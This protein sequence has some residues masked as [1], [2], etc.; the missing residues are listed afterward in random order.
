MVI[1][2]KQDVIAIMDE[3]LLMAQAATG[4]YLA[5]ELNGKD[6]YPCG[7][8]WV[9]IYSYRGKKIRANSWLGKALAE[10]GA[11]KSDYEKCFKIWDPS[12]SMLQNIDAKYAGA[13]AAA[14]VLKRYGFEAYAGERMD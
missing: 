7:F 1:E 6:A 8:A 14:D 11:R 10:L 5:K 2:N 12:K 4:E 3:A 13:R 9:N